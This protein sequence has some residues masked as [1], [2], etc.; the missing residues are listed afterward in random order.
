M[1]LERLVAVRLIDPHPCASPRLV[2]SA[3]VLTSAHRNKRS[4]PSV[5]FLLNDLNLFP[6]LHSLHLR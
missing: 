6:L 5:L 1:H 4:I 3:Q 2:S